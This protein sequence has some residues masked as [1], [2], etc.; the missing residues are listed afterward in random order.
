MPVIMVEIAVKELLECL[1]SCEQ[2][3]IH[4]MVVHAFIGFE[5]HTPSIAGIDRFGRI[6]N[7]A[8]RAGVKL[9]FENTEGEEYL[10]ALMDAFS[11]EKN[12][13]FCWDSG[14]EMCYNYSKDM[15]E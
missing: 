11:S 13:G 4:I 2:N 3:D 12:V 9:A 10:S 1:N 7:A 15:L 5:N 6:V 14:H 8:V